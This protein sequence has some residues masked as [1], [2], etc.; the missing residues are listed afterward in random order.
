MD[1]VINKLQLLVCGITAKLIDAL[2]TIYGWLA[3]TILF[4]INFYSG[5]AV[6]IAGIVV[7]VLLDA[8]W[9]I[10]VA[11]KSG[12]SIL[13]CRGRDTWLKLAV[14]LT[15]VTM[16]IIIDSIASLS[17]F[18]VKLTTTIVGMLICL[19]E[20]WS[21]V[22]SISILYPQLPILKLLRRALTGEIA[23]KLNIDEQD[24]EKYLNQ[25][26]EE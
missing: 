11:R 20:L 16:M 8:F 24:V 17:G 7:C 21:V 25:N 18:D 26:G 10:Y 23:H 15:F 6:V 3:A 22:A 1:F 5:Y 9:G 13:S 2:S 19:T 14:Y 4:I 12:K